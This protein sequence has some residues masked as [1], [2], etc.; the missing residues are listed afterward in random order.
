VVELGRPIVCTFAKP[1]D[2]VKLVKLAK[3][4]PY[5]SH[6]SNRIMFSS[7][8]A[9]AKGWIRML[10]DSADPD[11]P[12]ALTCVRHKSREPK[13]TALYFLVVRPDL[14]GRG[15][16]DLMIFDLVQQS[17]SKIIQLNV[18]KDNESAIRFYKRHGFDTIGE[19]LYDKDGKPH[20]WLMEL[21]SASD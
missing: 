5:T 11:N 19:S 10:Y 1:T 8:A 20:G 15:Y 6:F 21:K 12:M 17:P 4:S 16:G 13:S 9:Y 18:A 7:D 14:R 2:H 3:T